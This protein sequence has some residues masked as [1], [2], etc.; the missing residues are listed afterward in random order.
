[1]DTKTRAQY[2][3]ATLSTKY[4]SSSRH[5][6][7]SIANHSSDR[8]GV[9]WSPPYS[10][11]GCGLAWTGSGLVARSHSCCEQM[12]TMALQHLTNRVWL[13]MATISSSYELSSFS[14]SEPWVEVC[15]TDVVF[16]YAALSYSLLFD[17]LWAISVS[18]TNY[19]KKKLF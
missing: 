1:M 13:Q 17:K 11:L 15:D 8:G 6:Q 2:I 14:S 4:P 3:Q 9:S 7:S 18:I 10:M 5:P 19:C 12:C 16:V